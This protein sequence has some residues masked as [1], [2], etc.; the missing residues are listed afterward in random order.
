MEKTRIINIAQPLFTSQR[1]D[2]KVFVM[3][4]RHM[5]NFLWF[6]V[7]FSLL[8]VL[9]LVAVLMA[10]ISTPSIFS[11]SSEMYYRD[12]LIIAVMSYYLIFS[13]ILL[14]AWIN[15]YYSILIVTDERVVEI[16]Q[17]NLF[18]RHFNEMTFENIEDV[19]CKTNGILNTLFDV[20]DLDIQTAG[21]LRN[22][23]ITGIS[24][25]EIVS[26]II[27][28]L[29]SQAKS[30]KSP[31]ERLPST[32]VIGV[33]DKLV[34]YRDQKMPPIMNSSG[35]LK[36]AVGVLKQHLARRPKSLREKIDCWWWN[37]CNSSLIDFELEIK[38]RNG[39]EN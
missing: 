28:E 2:E 15:H 12:A 32:S 39:D 19:S 6:I 14:A 38:R 9:P 31:G 25:P 35:N 4:R 23:S 7:N 36:N 18:S 10:S 22:F 16:I 8:F 29:A 26:E 20:G 27:I 24:Y 3:S 13:M 17:K 11:V 34:V 5:I 33:I 37:T 1:N 30:G 21:S